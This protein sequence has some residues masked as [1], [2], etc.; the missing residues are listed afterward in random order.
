MVKSPGTPGLT[1]PSRP[2]LLDQERAEVLERP[3]KPRLAA[4]CMSQRDT[5]QQEANREP[6]T[7]TGVDVSA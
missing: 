7:E 2:G 3:T 1:A 5:L 4:R 6:V